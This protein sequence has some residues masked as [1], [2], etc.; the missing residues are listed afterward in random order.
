[1][2]RI[3]ILDSDHDDAIADMNEIFVGTKF[4]HTTEIE[5]KETLCTA[6]RKLNFSIK[7]YQEKYNH[8]L[9]LK[10]NPELEHYIEEI[11]SLGLKGIEL[12]IELEDTQLS[13]YFKTYLVFVKSV[14]DK[15]IQFINYR[16]KFS[17]KTF[18]SRGLIY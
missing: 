4:I 11:N 9:D 10:S 8:L 16:Y 17:E 7:K 6:I 15:T 14:L 13:Y 1:M 3:I 5:L 18:E 12:E 2:S